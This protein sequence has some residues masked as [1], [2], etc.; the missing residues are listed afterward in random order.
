[1]RSIHEMVPVNLD[2]VR[3]VMMRAGGGTVTFEVGQPF[4][5]FVKH[6]PDLSEC[7]KT[8]SCTRES[9]HVVPHTYDVMIAGGSWPSERHAI[10]GFCRATSL[11]KHKYVQGLGAPA[12]LGEAVPALGWTSSCLCC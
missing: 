9:K 5:L 3:K 10:T 12:L 2:G 1:M 11:N 7:I 4:Y 6:C 8:G